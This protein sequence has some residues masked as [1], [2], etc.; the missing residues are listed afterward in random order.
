MMIICKPKRQNILIGAVPFVM[1]WLNL[2]WSSRISTWCMSSV[3]TLMLT[4]RN[5]SNVMNAWL[6]FICIVLPVSQNSL[7]PINVSFAHSLAVKNNFLTVYFV[8]YFVW[9]ILCCFVCPVILYFVCFS[10]FSLEMPPKK[11]PINLGGP[12][13]PRSRG[14]SHEGET[15]NNW[16][17]QQLNKGLSDYNIALAKARGDASKVST[18]DIAIKNGLPPVT[19]W[20]RVTGRV[21]GTGYCSGG[22]RR[23][24]V[25]S[26]G[27]FKFISFADSVSFERNHFV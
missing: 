7:L 10:L 11:K 26:V 12:K 3:S 18:R 1:Y 6:H 4:K 15:Y 8:W 2:P 20:K 19:F 24:R 9:Y 16:T 13:P 23:P 17:L 27:K 22:A 14:A 21:K 25:L 5:G